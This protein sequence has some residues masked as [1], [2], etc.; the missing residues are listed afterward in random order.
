LPELELGFHRFLATIELPDS[1]RALARLRF[2]G[3]SVLF[4]VC[5]TSKPSSSKSS[6]ATSPRTTPRARQR[7]ASN[8]WRI[9]PG[10]SGVRATLVGIDER[11]GS[12]GA[13]ER[14]LARLIGPPAAPLPLIAAARETLADELF[15]RGDFE[16]AHALY[17]EL[18]AEPNDRDAVR[19]L[20]VKALGLEGSPRQRK[21]VFDL[22]IGAPGQATDSATAVYL[23]R[24]AAQRAL[25][26]P[27]ALP[28][29]AP[30]L[31]P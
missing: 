27:A 25:G 24:G 19:L 16:R 6:R 13:A 26:W 17:R 4:R 5:P 23:A 2:Q 18:L 20:Q 22:L 11:R 3:S 31:R 28:R 1:A 21:L 29:G 10:E 14:E 15:R 7:P 8:C 30:T 12:H 9:D